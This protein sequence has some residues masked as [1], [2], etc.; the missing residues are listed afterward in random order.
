MKNPPGPTTPITQPTIKG[1]V[2]A[3][4]P[5]IKIM[6]PEAPAISCAAI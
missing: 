4:K 2:M 3:P 1:P 6:P 5:L